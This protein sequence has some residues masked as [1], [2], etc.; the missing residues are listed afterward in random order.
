VYYWYRRGRQV[1]A[2]W[3][4]LV[5]G[6]LVVLFWTLYLHRVLDLGAEDP[7]VTQY[8]LAFPVPDAI[9]TVELSW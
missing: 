1:A 6:S 3:I 7:V 4:S 9:S 2:G 5:A 8:E